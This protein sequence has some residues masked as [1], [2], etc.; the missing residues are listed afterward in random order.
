V[1]ASNADRVILFS[2]WHL[3][4][5]RTARTGFFEAFLDAVCAGA[6][7]VFIVGDLFEAWPGPK[8]AALPG[9]AAALDAI[10]RL[11]ESGTRITILR[12][13]RDFL[14]DQRVADAYRFTLCAQEWRG[15]LAGRT[16]LIRHGDRWATDDRLHKL[17]RRLGDVAPVAWIARQLPLAF[18]AWFAGLW[19]RWSA[20]RRAQRKPG[21]GVRPDPE[22]L[23][24]AYASG[25]DVIAFGHW[26][27]EKLLPAAVALF[28]D[29][30]T[31]ERP[32]VVAASDG[33]KIKQQADKTTDAATGGPVADALGENALGTQAGLEHRTFVMLGEATVDPSGRGRACYAELV[34]GQPVR[35]RHYES[36]ADKG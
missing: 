16:I 30:A 26:H 32:Q 33:A 4:A 31:E 17:V 3:P 21:T 2:D 29:R 25:V 34:A 24:A 6:G 1:T 9:H 14:L 19:R 12:G 23:L 20:G 10:R 27:L 15:E 22:R 36:A 13:N 35:L 8:A 5:E 18:T 7:R 28:P 11:A